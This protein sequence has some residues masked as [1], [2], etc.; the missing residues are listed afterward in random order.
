MI[1]QW[2]AEMIYKVLTSLLNWINIPLMPETVNDNINEYLTLLFQ[3]GELF[4]YFI[5]TN[6]ISFGIPLLLVII[7]FKYG[8]YFVMWIVKKIP[9]AGM[10]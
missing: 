7:A 5:P 6:V 2:F 3:G 1:I 8:Y 10:S 9:M 4:Y